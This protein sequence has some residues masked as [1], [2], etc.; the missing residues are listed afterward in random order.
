MKKSDEGRPT[1][2]ARRYAWLGVPLGLLLCLLSFVPWILIPHMQGASI[3]AV[4]GIAKGMTFI[5][6]LLGL[7]GA[8]FSR[9]HFKTRTPYIDQHTPKRDVFINL[10]C[11]AMMLSPFM[12]VF[13][14]AAFDLITNFR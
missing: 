8:M 1:N 11:E 6:L 5:H 13:T 12:Y 7:G 3:N 4:F 9:F 10:A 14:W 2:L